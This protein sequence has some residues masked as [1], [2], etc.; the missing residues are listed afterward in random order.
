[1]DASSASLISSCINELDRKR[2]SN[3]GHPLSCQQTHHQ[4]HAF[5]PVEE[6][7]SSS[8]TYSARHRYL[9]LQLLPSF[10]PWL[11]HQ[12]HQLYQQQQQHNRP[13]ILCAIA[14]TFTPEHTRSWIT[15]VRTTTGAI[16]LLTVHTSMGKSFWACIRR[17]ETIHTVSDYKKQTSN[18]STITPASS[19]R[20]QSVSCNPYSRPAGI[21]DPFLYRI[22][23]ITINLL[24]DFQPQACCCLVSILDA[25]VFTSVKGKGKNGNNV[26]AKENTRKY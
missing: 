11:W 4:D 18:S 23:P 12:R 21:V 17:I 25:V 20:K 16:L 14:S 2:M 8:P 1:M 13:P 9:N 5:L 10:A 19:N 22:Q 3:L 15:M 7:L 26:E 24:I 6:S